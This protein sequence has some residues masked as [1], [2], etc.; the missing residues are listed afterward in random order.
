MKAVLCGIGMEVG[1]LIFAL[2][3]DWAGRIS[4]FLILYGILFLLMLAAWKSES[5]SLPTILGFSILFRLTLVPTIPIL[6]DDIYRYGW[7]GRVQRAGFNPY[8][9][10]PSAPQLLALRNESYPLINHKDIAAIYPPLTLMMNRTGT[11]LADRIKKLGVLALRADVVSQKVMVFVFDMGTIVLLMALLRQRHVPPA[12]LL[13][14][15]W[16]PLVVLEFAGSG[17][18]DSLAVFCLLGAIWFWELGQSWKATTALLA[19]FFAK[20]AA[21]LLVPFWVRKRRWGEVVFFGV[22]A[23]AGLY[24]VCRCWLMT[25]GTHHYAVH[26]Q[27]NGSLFPLLQKLMGGKESLTRWAVALILAIFSAAIGYRQ[28]DIARAAF[29]VLAAALLLAPT[30]YPWYLIW[31]IPLLCLFP[32]PAFLLW[33]ATVVLSYTVLPRYAVSQ[34]WDL[35]PAAQVVEYAPVYAS[36]VW[37][38]AKSFL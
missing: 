36:L 33:N 5:L 19:S 12:R 6:S 35:H 14:Y 22:M 13:L 8:H 24:E 11:Y 17:H 2:V 31:I 1:F 4:L 18:N 29:G 16:N 3:G 32:H 20:Y 9:L 34:I 28:K 10:P 21:I 38:Y 25:L 7:E 37:N 23:T 15:A 26:W 27:F 30:V